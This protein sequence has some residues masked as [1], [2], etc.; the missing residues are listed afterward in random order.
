[1]ADGNNIFPQY[2]SLNPCETPRVKHTLDL[3]TFT[4]AQATSIWM[5]K[6]SQAFCHLPGLSEFRQ[7]SKKI[8][9]CY[10]CWTDNKIGSTVVTTTWPDTRE[11]HSCFDRMN[12][13]PRIMVLGTNLFGNGA[14]IFR[15]IE[16][17]FFLS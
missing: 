16:T 2:Y 12:P 6:Q 13:F 7:L 17:P 9:R 11:N 8:N 15:N 1:M 10:N 14:K 5:F 4:P 3:W